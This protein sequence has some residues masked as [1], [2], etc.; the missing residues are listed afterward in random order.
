VI[1]KRILLVDDEKSILKALERLFFDSDYEL[2]TAN[3][4]EEGLQ[5]LTEYPVDIVVSDMRMPGMDGHQFLKKVKMLYPST[6]RLILSGYADEKEIL[7]SL[8]DGSSNLYLFKPWNG[9]DLITK[10]AQIFAARQIFKHQ[11]VLDLANGLENLS[12][13]TGIYNSV[14]R[15][16]DQDA[17]AGAVARVIETDPAV[18]A[19]VLRIVN[20]AFYNVKTGSVAQAITYLGL[21][22]VKSIVLS[23][24]LLKSVTIKVPPFNIARLTNHAIM[25]N[26]FMT[27][28]YSGLLQKQVP[29]AL[30]TAGL[31]HNLGLAMC[32]HYFPDIYKRLVEERLKQPNKSITEFEKEIMGVTHSELGGYLLNWWGLPYPIVECA[33]F[34]HDPVHS[35]VMDKVA[36]SVTHIAN[37]YAWKV[38]NPNMNQKLEAQVFPVLNIR[39]HDCEKLLQAS[40]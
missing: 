26:L 23:C 29:D 31:L 21:P 5:I 19:A 39:Q 15:L 33:L 22:V 38:V 9:E 34:Y 7:N 3:S 37:Y 16:I 10:I 14:C 17:D 11:A 1:G 12:L 6:T 30:A 32:L 2:F 20:S 27:K 18:T 25:T 8:I 4:G 28:I 13:V 40:R 24:S 35:A 36:V